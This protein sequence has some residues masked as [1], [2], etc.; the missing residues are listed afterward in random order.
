MRKRTV[1]QRAKVIAGRG[2]SPAAGCPL[3][4]LNKMS[5]AFM[6]ILYDLSEVVIAWKNGRS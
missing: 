5:G 3:E 1:H 6:L 4:F 2:L